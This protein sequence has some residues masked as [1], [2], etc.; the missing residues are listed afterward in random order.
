MPKRGAASRHLELQTSSFGNV[1]VMSYVNDTNSEFLMEAGHHR[2]CRRA[3][4]PAP[5]AT[6]P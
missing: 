4:G 2:S 6:P 5:L 1:R 3:K